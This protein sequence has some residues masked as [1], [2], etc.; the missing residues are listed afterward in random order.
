M[1]TAKKK[2]SKKS[3]PAKKSA[4]AKSVAKKAP[5]KKTKSVAKAT[6]NKPAQK[7]KAKVPRLQLLKRFHVFSAFVGLLIAVAA[8]SLMGS[9]SANLTVS[10][11][12]KDP[13]ASSGGTVLGPAIESIATVEYRYL[14]AGAFV[15]FAL[16]SVLLATV[17]RKRYEA[18]VNNATSGIRWLVTGLVM[19]IL[20]ELVAIFAGVQDVVTLKMIGLLVIVTAA[21]SWLAE[22]EN[23]QSASPKWSAYSLSLLTGFLAW[24]PMLSAVIATYVYGLERFSWFVYVLILLM[25]IGGIRFA[26]NSYRY[27]KQPKNRGEYINWEEKYLSNELFTKLAVAAVLFIA[28]MD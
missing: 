3:T 19:G 6:A 2:S 22:R 20:M 13:I 10:Y 7:S 28:L 18:G 5:A 17:L 16:L 12:A 25:L 21:L 24:L 9:K 14:I 8:V 26:A 15:V 1:A 27:I 11:S 23:K 4:A